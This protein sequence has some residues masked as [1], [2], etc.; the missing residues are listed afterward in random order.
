MQS[1]RN[2]IEKILKYCDRRIVDEKKLKDFL[3]GPLPHPETASQKY[4][5]LVN[6]TGRIYK[7][8]DALKDTEKTLDRP[9]MFKKKR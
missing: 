4:L 5:D 2:E 9:F 1:S 7:S 8:I 6:L 3:N